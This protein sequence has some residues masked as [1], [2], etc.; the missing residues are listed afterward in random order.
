MDLFDGPVIII[1]LVAAAIIGIIYLVVRAEKKRTENLK[2]KA[3]MMGLSFSEKTPDDFIS[4]LS[5]FK[6]FTEGHSKKAHNLIEG[7]AQGIQYSI[8]DYRYTVGAGKHSQTHIQTVFSAKKDNMKLPKFSMTPEYFYHKI[9]DLL[10]SKDIDFV[11]KPIF[12]KKYLLKGSDETAIRNTFKEEILSFFERKKEKIAIQANG[13]KMIL[14]RPSKNIKPKD[15]T[16]FKDESIKIVEL[17][18]EK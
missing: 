11:N 16:K 13:N 17:F 2:T 6:L 1:I 8:F 3:H 18:S 4:T 5:E 10:G 14:Y 7:S 12:S 9:G 15:L